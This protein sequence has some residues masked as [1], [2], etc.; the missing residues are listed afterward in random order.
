M[1]QFNRG[2]NGQSEQYISDAQVA[3]IAGMT[4]AEFMA[5]PIRERRAFRQRVQDERVLGE[6]TAFRTEAIGEDDEDAQREKRARTEFFTKG[7][8]AKFNRRRDEVTGELLGSDYSGFDHEFELVKLAAKL[9]SRDD[10]QSIAKNYG[11]WL[12]SIRDATHPFDALTTGDYTAAHLNTLGWAG[13]GTAAITVNAGSFR[14]NTLRLTVAPWCTEPIIYKFGSAQQRNDDQVWYG[15]L[16]ETLTNAGQYAL[17][18]DVGMAT[19]PVQNF[20]IAGPSPT[21]INAAPE[22]LYA[23]DPQPAANY[24]NAYGLSTTRAN[25]RML[26]DPLNTQNLNVGDPITVVNAVKNNLYGDFA[27]MSV[28]HVK[29]QGDNPLSAV[30]GSC[31][32]S[33]AVNVMSGSILDPQYDPFPTAQF[34]GGAMEI[35]VTCAEQAT[36]EV[37]C[38][39]QNETKQVG[40]T[41]LTNEAQWRQNVGFPNSPEYTADPN[42][43]I[44]G[45]L[46]DVVPALAMTGNAMNAVS[47][48]YIP[49]IPNRVAFMTLNAPGQHSQYLMNPGWIANAYYLGPATGKTATAPTVSSWYGTDPGDATSGVTTWTPST[50]QYSNTQLLWGACNVSNNTARNTDSMTVPPASLG[51]SRILP[52]FGTG[53]AYSFGS[54]YLANTSLY[55]SASPVA[56]GNGTSNAGNPRAIP[57]SPFFRINTNVVNPGYT[58]GLVGQALE[59]FQNFNVDSVNVPAKILLGAATSNIAQCIKQGMP[60]FEVRAIT[61][62]TQVQVWFK[63]FYRLVIG[64]THPMYEYSTC[65]TGRSG[66]HIGAILPH[67]GQAGQ[68]YTAA[69]AHKDAMASTYR[70]VSTSDST[71]AKAALAG[72]RSS[73]SESMVQPQIGISID[74]KALQNGVK[75]VQ[76]YLQPAAKAIA[77]FAAQFFD[78]NKTGV[79]AALVEAG[80]HAI[81]GDLLKGAEVALNALSRKFGF[82]GFLDNAVAGSHMASTGHT[83]RVEELEA[84]GWRKAGNY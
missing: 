69:E 81:E 16:Q 51:F 26:G 61:G 36:C 47:S 76:D 27:D 10:P 49:V 30:K 3:S 9:A 79:A 59:P 45:G 64:N 23:Y 39:A 24:E 25:D 75:M 17:Q 44:F 71:L 18:T 21:P 60:Q 43:Y 11:A 74:K 20:V 54:W 73:Y 82:G 33:K 65:Q 8:S 66:E 13:R 68:G 40:M 53:P 83:Q 56:T 48:W 19:I 41:S 42:V 70:V 78:N 7:G 6:R 55:S 12:A 31:G 4:M 22:S 50:L 72:A 58:Q 67:F 57:Y 1:R 62:A 14:E 34:L 63:M 15:A 38:A 2:S 32:D 80:M 28:K 37:A 46:G 77:P 52:S 35:R 5:L 84:D 29:Y